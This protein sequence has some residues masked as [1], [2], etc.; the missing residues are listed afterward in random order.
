MTEELAKKEAP[1]TNETDAGML[2]KWE[3]NAEVM[4]LWKK[5]NTPGLPDLTE[6]TKI[7]VEFDKIYYRSDTYLLGK[8]LIDDGVDSNGV[9]TKEDDSVWTDLTEEG[10]DEKTRFGATKHFVYQLSAG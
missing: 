8:D 10:P 3:E 2:V 4:E 6:H 7:S 1:L 9:S 5:M